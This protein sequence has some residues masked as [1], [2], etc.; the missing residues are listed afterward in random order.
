[1]RPERLSPVHQTADLAELVC[2]NSLRGNSLD[3]GAGLLKEEMRRMGSLVVQVADAVAVPAG[4]ALAVD[5]ALF[6]RRTAR[7]GR[8]FFGCSRFPACRF[9]STHPPLAESCPECG[10]ACLY[11]KQT[12]RDGPVVFCGNP[13]CHYHR[14]V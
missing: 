3:Q 13:A 14:S 1:M 2:S 8:S 10:E 4:S 12:R 7:E 9:T 5:R 11:R 6:A